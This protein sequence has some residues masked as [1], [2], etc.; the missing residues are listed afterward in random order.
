MHQ[1]QGYDLYEVCGQ[2]AKSHKAKSD[3]EQTL[4]RVIRRERARQLNGHDCLIV[5]TI[6]TLHAILDECWCLD[7]TVTVLIAQPG[8]SRKAMSTDQAELLE[9]T[10]PY[11]SETYGTR[12]RVLCSE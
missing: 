11:L 7:P 5:G 1:V 3:I 8:L 10:E 6:D 12:F 2:A 9:C 4:R